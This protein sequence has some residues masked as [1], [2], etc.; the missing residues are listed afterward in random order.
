MPV[1]TEGFC[2][3]MLID[4]D[5]RLAAGVGGAARHLGDAAGLNRAA[6]S[7]L[8]NVVV[9]AC[10]Q[11]FQHLSGSRPHLDVSL[12]RLADRIEVALC[13]E[14]DSS[15]AMG[16]DA[17]AGFTSC[18]SASAPGGRGVS[19]FRGIDRVQYESRGSTAITRLTKYITQ[20]TRPA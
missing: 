3:R 7:E 16:L 10:E 17:I 8:E 19:I 6:A 11:A 4:A 2:V 20:A 15:P 14:G 13:H 1:T 12:M 18:F 5:S 9:A